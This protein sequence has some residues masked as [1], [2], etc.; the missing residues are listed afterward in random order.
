L[1][2]GDGTS[3]SIHRDDLGGTTQMVVG[4]F[5]TRFSSQ[6]AF[7]GSPIG[8]LFVLLAPKIVST[9]LVVK[10]AVARAGRVVSATVS[11]TLED[12]QTVKPTTFRCRATLAGKTLRPVRQCTWRLPASAK[13]KRL[14]ISAS[15]DYHGVPFKTAAR[16]LRVR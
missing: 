13:R 1:R 14:V 9:S 2:P 6:E 5:T 4:S 3:F 16:S 15:G 12:R 10:P 8:T 11:L 7:D